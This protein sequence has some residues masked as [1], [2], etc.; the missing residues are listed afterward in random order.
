MWKYRELN[1][2]KEE[3]CRREGIDE[4]MRDRYNELGDASPLFR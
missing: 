3:L 4:S 2:E 1:K